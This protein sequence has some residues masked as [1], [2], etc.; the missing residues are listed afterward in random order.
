MMSTMQLRSEHTYDATPDEVFEMRSDPAWRAKVCE[1]Q[2]VVSHDI[3]IEPTDQGYVLVNHQVQPTAGLPDLAK[4]FVGDTTTV[5]QREEWADRESATVSIE[6]HGVP[7]SARGTITLRPAGSGTLEVTV[8]DAK[9]KVPV[10]CRKL[11]GLLVQAIQAGLDAEARV[12]DA[13][14]AG[15]R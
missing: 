5:L 11:E 14:L 9:V 3:S 7:S 15:E 4:K 13:W 12:G 2:R 10:V 8:L 1:A 6:P